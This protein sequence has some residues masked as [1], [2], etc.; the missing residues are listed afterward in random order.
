MFSVIYILS[1]ISTFLYNNIFN[2]NNYLYNQDR[3]ERYNN[4]RDKLK[5]IPNLATIIEENEEDNSQLKMIE[6][7]NNK[8]FEK[9]KLVKY[10]IYI[11]LIFNLLKVK[12]EKKESNAN[13]LNTNESNTKNKLLLCLDK[14]I[15][16]PFDEDFLSSSFSMENVGENISENI[17]TIAELIQYYQEINWFN[18]LNLKPNDTFKVKRIKLIQELSEIVEQLF[19]QETS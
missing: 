18:I 11:K 10:S 5:F 14:L 6:K 16:Y 3:Q 8:D 2:I 15:N 4:Y 13:E 19:L 9:E 7:Y 1:Q 12:L 17:N